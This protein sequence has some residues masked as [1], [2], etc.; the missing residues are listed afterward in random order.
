MT[1]IGIRNL[2]KEFGS[3]VAVDD[4][5]LDVPEGDLFFLLGPSGCGKTTLLRMLA[6][7]T[8]PTQGNI[9]FNDRDVTRLA[10]NKR[11]TGMVFQGYALWPH[12]T[13]WQNVAF[14][15]G[16]RKVKGP[17]REKR[18]KQALEL[19]QMGEYGQR[20][21]NQLSGG[22]QQRVAL[23]RALVI[24]PTVLLLDEPLSN[25]DAKLRLEMRGQIRRICKE[26]GITAV[27]VTHDQKEALSMADHVALM[28]DGKVI[29]V[30]SPRELYER[31]VN[32]FAADFLGESNFIEASVKGQQDGELL[33]ETAAGPL[34]SA[35]FPETIMSG[36]SVVCS[37]RPESIHLT[38]T[39]DPFNCFE[40]RRQDVVYLGEMAQHHLAA[41]D[42]N[43]KLKAL[44]LN[45]QPVSGNETVHV[46]FAARDVV[47]L[48]GG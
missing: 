2:R 25:L 31:P 29:Q 45:P 48:R 33:L 22:Q 18:V 44:E 37:I 23:A 21:P 32:R 30:G 14:G 38:D 19:V 36:D 13:V 40:A 26:A 4:V 43:L 42:G 16:V 3:V 41:G 46:R 34:R 35:A 27:Y 39:P 28:Q 5:Y 20:R 17:E 9:R 10:P 12:M 47:V 11:N 6:G 7:F 1:T 15:L 8:D 24:E